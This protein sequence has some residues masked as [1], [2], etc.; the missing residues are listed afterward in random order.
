M[1][2]QPSFAPI[3]HGGNLSRATEIFGLPARGWL[4]L[5]TGINPNGYADLSVTSDGWAQLP[6]SGALR[7]LLD[8]ARRAYGVAD[9]AAVCAAPGTQA[10][11]QL[12]PT[13]RAAATVAVVSPTYGEHG[14]VWRLAGHRVVEIDGPERAA[15]AAVVVVTSPNNPDG[16]VF[17]GETLEQLRIRL[18]RRKG[19]LIVDEAFA[20]VMPEVSIAGNAGAPGL[21]V[22]RSFGKFY[23]LAGLRLGFAIGSPET[24]GAIENRLGPWAV[25]GPAIEIGSRALTDAHWA[26]ETRK[27]LA[28]LRERLDG[29]LEAA[30]LAVV[31]GTD[32]FRLVRC[33][34]AHSVFLRL[35]R[36]GIL[37]REFPY[38][39]D[40]LR[41]GLPGNDVAFDR[42]EKALSGG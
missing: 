26:A 31:G 3:A 6:S 12:L 21:V 15:G 34:D 41:F 16:R 42:L 18:A 8:A 38:R 20:D 33:D 37:V 30:G 7:S 32:L 1:Q 28:R 19:L 2:I 17:D 29:V 40:W 23:G 22:L 36:S 39:P 13:L 35:G 27:S 10:L 25:S 4:D 11:I 14:H 24:I 5:S 9:A